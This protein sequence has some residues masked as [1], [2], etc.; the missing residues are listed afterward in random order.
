MNQNHND[1]LIEMMDIYKCILLFSPL[2]WM[3]E[4]F[5]D[6]ISH[7]SNYYSSNTQ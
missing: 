4:K 3:F 2:F 6:K 5:Q 1:F 7:K